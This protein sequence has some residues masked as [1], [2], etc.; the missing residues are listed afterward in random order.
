MSKIERKQITKRA[1]VYLLSGPRTGREVSRRFG[2]AV[3]FQTAK[4]RHLVVRVG[5][6]WHLTAKGIEKASQWSYEM[7]LNN[8][9][10]DQD[11]LGGIITTPYGM[12]IAEANDAR[13]EAE[14]KRLQAQN[15]E[16][17]PVAVGLVDK[18]YESYDWQIR[19]IDFLEEIIRNMTSNRNI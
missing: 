1:C 15:W 3:S 5:D 10:P 13:E 17:K 19:H 12:G 4:K 7:K 8:E 16:D 18:G 11:Y 9:H 14:D 2:S 6:T